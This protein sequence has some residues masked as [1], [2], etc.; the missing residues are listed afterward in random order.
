MVCGLGCV[1]WYLMNLMNPP[2]FL[3]TFLLL[4]SVFCSTFIT[5]CK[6]FCVSPSSDISIGSA[7]SCDRAFSFLFWFPSTSLC[8]RLHFPALLHN[9][10]RKKGLGS[11]TLCKSLQIIDPLPAPKHWFSTFLVFFYFLC[12]NNVMGTP[13]PA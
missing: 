5:S 10:K 7:F 2:L 13:S 12:R 4:Q 6:Y 9:F 11:K 1:L 8:L 3:P